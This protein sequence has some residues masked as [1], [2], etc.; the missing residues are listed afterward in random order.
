[1][2]NINIRTTAIAGGLGLVSISG[3]TAATTLG[4]NGAGF[5]DAGAN[6]GIMEETY[7]DNITVSDTIAGITAT[8]G[9]QSIVGTPNITLGWSTGNGNGEWDSYAGWDTPPRDVVQT[10]YR[11]SFMTLTFEPDSPNVGA[12]ITAFDLDEFTNGGETEIDWSILNGSTTIVSGTETRLS[13]AFNGGQVTVNT[14]MTEA[15]AIANAGNNLT[16][17]LDF[18]AG[19]SSYQAMDNLSFD[20]VVVPEPSSS[21]LA[22]VGLG[23][24]AMRRRR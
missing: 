18:V 11:R 19:S 24:M 15:Q 10:D 6:G 9:V 20:Q 13:G 5:V 21:L 4:F 1:M 2:K 8:S 23:A 3:A 7:G 22:A 12:L 17:R 16:L 14:G